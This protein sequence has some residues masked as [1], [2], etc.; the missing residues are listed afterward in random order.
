MPWF[1][2]IPLCSNATQ[3]GCYV[4]WNTMLEGGDPYHWVAEKR[5]D[6]IDCVNPLSWK[7]DDAYVDSTENPGSIPMMNYNVLFSRLPALHKNVVGARCG[8]E[9]ML[10]IKQKPIVSGYTS[11]L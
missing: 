9:G 5:L 3:T 1:Q 8:K 2:Q 7:T 6:K 10:W 11:A 4:T